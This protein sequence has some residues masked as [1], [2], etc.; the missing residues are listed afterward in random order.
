MWREAHYFLRKH[1]TPAA[2]VILLINVGIFIAGVFFG[3]IP[4]FERFLGLLMETPREAVGRLHLW[5]FVTYMFL[6]NGFGHLFFNMLVLWFF[7]PRLEYRWGTANFVRFYLTV[8]VGAGI[9]HALVSYA[10]GRPYET[11]LGA[12]GALYGILLGYA[13]YYPEETALF[14]FVLPI[15]MKYL[16][17]ILCVASFLFS[18]QDNQPGGISHITHLGGLL[19]AA[20]YLL[21]GGWWTRLR[22]GRRRGAVVEDWRKTYSNRR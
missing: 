6:H 5:Q 15:K 12:S 11:M 1:L 8:G 10:L 21:G 22:E 13:L 17:T 9:F 3:F 20:V 16:V 7:A 2:M 18:I 14:Y 4:P 19:V